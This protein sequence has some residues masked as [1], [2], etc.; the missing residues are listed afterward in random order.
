VKLPTGWYPALDDQ[1]M[2]AVG[3]M[4]QGVFDPGY[5]LSLHEILDTGYWAAAADVVPELANELEALIELVDYDR[6]H[7]RQ[8]V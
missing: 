5:K 1:A 7:I 3:F 2:L 8:L 6:V 4:L